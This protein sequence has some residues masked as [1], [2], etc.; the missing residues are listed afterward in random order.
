M[1]IKLPY[2]LLLVV[3]LA[4]ACSSTIPL[5]TNLSDQTLLMA[6]N[7]NIKANVELITEVPNGQ[8]EQIYFL[9]NGNR[10]SSQVFENQSE[11]AFR[12]MWSA[13]FDNKFNSFSR[14]EMDIKVTLKELFLS[15]QSATSIGSQLLTGHNKSNV[16]AIGVFHVE[17]M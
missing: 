15:E 12:N 2:F 5:Q 1:N 4:N 14:D 13:Y 8:V 7:K 3:L 9:R 16:E 17:V 10:S 6:E 11:T